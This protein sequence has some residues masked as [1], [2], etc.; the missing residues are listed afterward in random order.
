MILVNRLVLNLR[1]FDSEC[2]G[3]ESR[4]GT[5]VLDSILAFTSNRWVGNMGAP[6]DY[7]DWDLGLDVVPEEEGLGNEETLHEVDQA[8]IGSA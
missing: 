2:D 3:A 5:T 8:V 1:N 6:L 7:T 4:S